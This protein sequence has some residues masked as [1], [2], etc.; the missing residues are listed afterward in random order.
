MSAILARA[1]AR[2]AARVLASNKGADHQCVR[3]KNLDTEE[4]IQFVKAWPGLSIAAGQQHV[5]LVVAEDLSG[6][7]PLEHVA[8]A[9]C[10]ITHYR[11]HNRQGLVY[12]ETRIQSDEQGLQNMF[13]LSDSNFLDKS[14]DG[15]AVAENGIPEGN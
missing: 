1:A 11:N 5:R 3:I 9:G 7:I 4:V 2:I 15:H 10:T 12:V 6:L 13:T 8:E 14:F